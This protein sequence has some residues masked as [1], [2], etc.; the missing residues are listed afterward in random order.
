MKKIFYKML[1]LALFFTLATACYD[2]KGNYDYVEISK[3]TTTGL[4]DSYSRIAYQDVLH[5]EPTVTSDRAGEEFD[6]MWTLNL[7]KGSGTT[8]A[9]IKIELDT[10]GTERILDFPVN[11]NQGFYDLTLRVT[12]RNNG[13]DAFHVMSL[14]VITKFSEGFYFLKDMG[15]S[16]DL[17]LHM[18]DNSKITDIIQ[19]AEG[20]ALSASPVG[21]GLDP[22]YCFIDTE[23]GKYVI[24]KALTVCSENDVRILNVENMS[25]I[26]THSTM[27]H[28][29][30]APEEKPYYVWRNAYGV[31]YMSDKGA[32]F[33][34]QA[35]I[36]NLLGAGKFGFPAM[37]NDEEDS[38]PNK[39]GVYVG[40]Y[41]FF[42]DELGDR[43]LYLDFNGGL[44]ALL[45]NVKDSQEDEKYT[46]NGIK[47]QLK[48]FVRNFTGNKNTG[49]A[50]FE[51][52][53]VAGK[54]YL[55]T[56]ALDDAPYNPIKKV[57]EIA[58]A[59]KL[60]GATLCA[61]NELKAKVIYFVTDNKLYMYD[62]DLNTEEELTPENLAS[63]EE[64]TYIGNRYWTQK[65]DT[66]R[67]FDYL[68]IATCK[69]GKY[70]VHMY[71]TLGGKTYGKPK[72]V[73]E[74]EG[75]IMKIHYVSPKMAMTSYEYFPGS[76]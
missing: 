17:D 75:K 55:Y 32:Y 28:S 59:S 67:N 5:I 42:F 69:D 24:T 52:A 20:E 18:W 51:D 12:N 74:G 73:F 21:L 65:D 68:A 57:T 50:L 49:Y 26:Y 48:F 9:S 66:E 30:V 8:S 41:Y 38:R 72:Y 39:Q 13:V 1:F 6:Y 70:K 45:N 40:F 43:F 56:M 63:G 47:H 61:S 71:E 33:S 7:T 62:T 46:P 27:F 54:H 31:G 35:S 23:T 34:A 4:E 25:T 44:S 11:V 58:S 19:K 15:N 64:I 22:G 10:I 37:V 3:I 16:T 76:F 29:G 36:W 14:S 60:N 2:D 53:D